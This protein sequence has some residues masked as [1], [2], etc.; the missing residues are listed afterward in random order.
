MREISLKKESPIDNDKLVKAIA[1]AL[2]NIKPPTINNSIPN[3]VI[4]EIKIPEQKAPVKDMGSYVIKVNR[5]DK[6]LI[7]SMVVSPYEPV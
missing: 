2:K 5:D 7:Y 3:V 1:E 4:P 6:G